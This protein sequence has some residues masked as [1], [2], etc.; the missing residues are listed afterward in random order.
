MVIKCWRSHEGVC[1]AFI[2]SANTMRALSP[3]RSSS[4]LFFSFLK[5]ERSVVFLKWT[6]GADNE[7][8]TWTSVRQYDERGGR[9]GEL[10]RFKVGAKPAVGFRYSLA[11]P[12]AYVGTQSFRACALL[13]VGCVALRGNTLC[14]H[15]GTCAQISACVV[16]ALAPCGFQWMR[17]T[18]YTQF[19]SN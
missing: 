10:Q 7:I 1:T 18:K 14:L 3:H 2:W 16:C 4:F 8:S 9:L 17:E 13:G 11:L 6:S 5:M 12:S 15:T 19:K